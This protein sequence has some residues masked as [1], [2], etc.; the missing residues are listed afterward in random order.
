[1]EA[2]KAK[3]SPGPNASNRADEGTN[4]LRP[5]L[6]SLPLQTHAAAVNYEMPEPATKVNFKSIMTK[7]AQQIIDA[8]VG[9]ENH[10]NAVH[11]DAVSRRR[12]LKSGAA[13]SPVILTLVS[14][15]VLAAT[16]PTGSAVAS[17]NVSG[18]T[19]PGVPCSGRT[20]AY[21]NQSQHFSD[22][23]FPYFPTTD[24]ANI[25]G[26]KTKFNQV[27]TK[28]VSNDPTLLACLSGTNAVRSHIVAALLNAAKGW[29][30][31]FLHVGN[32]IAIWD[33]YKSSGGGSS[34]YWS[35][36]NGVILYA[37]TTLVNG[38]TVAAGAGSGGIVGWLQENMPLGG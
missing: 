23:I 18:H 13:I 31:T 3:Y 14:K 30:S 17:L 7:D 25:T 16:C 24:S 22:W 33:S 6:T 38:Q 15:P 37:N 8:S 27:F 19:H 9:S 32:V 1:M 5:D 21:W 28:P 35:P 11:V 26:K 29:N 10:A 34:G 36:G 4:R 2:D 20:P 12:L